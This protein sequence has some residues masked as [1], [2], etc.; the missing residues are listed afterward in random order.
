MQAYFIRSLKEV[1]SIAP[2]AL[3]HFGRC[4]HD[5]LRWS[6]VIQTDRTKPP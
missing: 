5:G 6:D 4:D 3:G 1:A 2:D